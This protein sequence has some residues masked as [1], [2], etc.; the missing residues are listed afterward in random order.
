M[1]E[2]DDPDEWFDRGVAL[3]R[4]GRRPAAAEAAYKR[5]IAAGYTDAWLHVGMVISGRRGRRDDEQA[6]YRA[7]ASSDDA[8]IASLAALRLANMLDRLDGD[9][10]QA[11]SCFELAR[12]RGSQVTKQHAHMNLG[13]LL[14]YMGEREAAETEIRSFVEARCA[15]GDAEMT[16]FYARLARRITAVAHA[17]STR[18]ALRRYRIAEYRFSRALRPYLLALPGVRP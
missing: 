3:H 14:A 9:L 11:R 1:G 13:L 7:A 16:A 8:E 5:A 2:P 12:D 4:R 10:A 17:R 6:A 15:P 18:S